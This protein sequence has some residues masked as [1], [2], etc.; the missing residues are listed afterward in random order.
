MASFNKWETKIIEKTHG[1]VGS[2]KQS[3]KTKQSGI[4]VKMH[5]FS[6]FQ[7]TKNSVLA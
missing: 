6:T 7:G 3:Q 2:E 4:T 5:R 1:F